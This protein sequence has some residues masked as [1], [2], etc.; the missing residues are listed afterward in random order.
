M[1]TAM[2]CHGETG[3]LCVKGGNVIK[4]YLNREGRT[5][6]SIQGGWLRTGDIARMDDEVYIRVDRAKDNGAARGEI[7]PKWKAPCSNMMRG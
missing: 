6:E 4:G 3:E 2:I 7:L 5:S 1:L